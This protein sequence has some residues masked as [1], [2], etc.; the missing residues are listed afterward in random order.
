MLVK[1]WRKKL[2][3]S[4]RERRWFKENFNRARDQVSELYALLASKTSEIKKLQEDYEK[5]K[6]DSELWERAARQSIGLVL[7]WI[8]EHDFK[9]ILHMNTCSQCKRA[10]ETLQKMGFESIFQHSYELSVK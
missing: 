8:Q 9:N 7:G 2:K 1:D 10:A 6:S 4:R 3:K 5:S